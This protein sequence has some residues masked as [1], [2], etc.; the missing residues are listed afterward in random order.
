MPRLFVCGG[1][2][3]INIGVQLAKNVIWVGQIVTAENR[4]AARHT[5][6]STVVRFAAE[7][8]LCARAIRF[9]R[10]RQR[11]DAWLPHVKRCDPFIPVCSILVVS[12]E[13]GYHSRSRLTK[14]G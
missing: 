7:N 14:A 5:T 1:V 9:A 8:R 11:A 13:Q 10:D 3:T 12:R 4:L 2:A 6:L